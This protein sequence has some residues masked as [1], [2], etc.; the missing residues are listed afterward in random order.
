MVR[1]MPQVAPISPQRRMKRSWEV[2]SCWA[3]VGLGSAAVDGGARVAVAMGSP[4]SVITESIASGSV[5]SG[6]SDLSALLKIGL[7][8]KARRH[9]GQLVSRSN[10]AGGTVEFYF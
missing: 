4:V 9:E 1:L 8:T 3:G 6:V 7:N 10:S 5:L 2:R